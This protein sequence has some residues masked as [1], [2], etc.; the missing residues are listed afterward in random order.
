M[1][2][3]PLQLAFAFLGAEPDPPPAVSRST[4]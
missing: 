4:I 3:E 1:P 2:C